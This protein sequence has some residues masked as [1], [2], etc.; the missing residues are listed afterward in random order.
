M[1]VFRFFRRPFAAVAFPFFGWRFANGGSGQGGETAS[2]I[3]QRGVAAAVDGDF[4][5]F[6]HEHM[7]CADFVLRGDAAVQV[8]QRAFD[9]QLAA[10]A[11]VP[12][13]VFEALFGGEGGEAGEVFGGVLLVCGEDVDADGAVL[14][15][16]GNDACLFVDTEHD[17]GRLV[18]NG[19]DGGHGDAA[20]SGR[21]VGGDDVNAGGADGHG[22]AEGK[23]QG[24]R[25][26]FG[27]AAVV[28]VGSVPCSNFV[29]A[30]F[31]DGLRLRIG[32]KAVFVLE[33]ASLLMSQGRQQAGVAF[34]SFA[35]AHKQRG[36]QVFYPTLP[37]WRYARQG[38]RR[39]IRR[40][41]RRFPLRD[42]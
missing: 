30:S 5:D 25:H 42:V 3:D 19:G 33:T 14:Q 40:L 36:R 10:A 15:K 20:A 34:L 38:G 24:M 26:G 12:D 18:G 35:A 31:S 27:F 16:N 13:V 8:R 11:S 39:F 1:W 7:V 22:V 28:V 37:R 4:A 6:D 32:G 17:G 29:E 2:E 9:L 41:R 23:L 21:A